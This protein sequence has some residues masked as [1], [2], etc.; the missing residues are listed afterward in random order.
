MI[1]IRISGP[2]WRCE[3]TG[4]L[5]AAP[6][7]QRRI[8]LVLVA[9]VADNDVIGHAGK[10]PWRLKSEMQH[11]RAITMGKPVV[12]GRKTYLS[13]GQA[14]RWPHQHRGEPRSSFH[15]AGRARRAE[16]RGG[17]HGGAW[18]RVAARRGRDRHHRRRR[19]LTRDHGPRRSAADHARAL[20]TSAATRNFPPINPEIW[21]EAER[22]EHRAGPDDEASFTVHHLSAACD[23]S[24]R[25]GALRH[26]RPW[27]RRRMPHTPR[28]RVVTG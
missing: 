27:V 7:E 26:S 14:A 8:D 21:R 9:A 11:F 13:I 17:A 24:V 23:A 1:R 28:N 5:R 2:R 15:G 20:A 12:M 16:R 25:A 4:G 18:R 22:R 3:R 19:D 6:P 10:L